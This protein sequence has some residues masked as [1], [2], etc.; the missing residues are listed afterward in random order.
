MVDGAE[1]VGVT[2]TAV[3]VPVNGFDGVPRAHVTTLWLGDVDFEGT[4]ETVAQVLSTVDDPVWAGVAEVVGVDDTFG[5]EDEQ[6]TVLLV[7][8]EWFVRLREALLAGGLL[9]ASEFTEFK[10]HVTLG[11]T[12]LSDDELGAALDLV[13]STVSFEGVQVGS[14]EADRFVE[15]DDM[16]DVVDVLGGDTNGEPYV[17]PEPGGDENDID[18][19]TGD[20]DELTVLVAS[21]ETNGTFEAVLIV[22]GVRTGDGREIA[23]GGLTHRDLPLPLMAQTVT[24]DHGGHAGAVLV[25]S[26]VELERSE[27]GEWVGRGVFDGGDVAQDVRRMVAEGVLNGVSADL[28]DVVVSWEFDG[29]IDSEG[30]PV[31]IMRIEQGRIMGATLTPFPAMQEAKVTLVASAAGD[32]IDGSASAVWSQ[33]IVDGDELTALV[34]SGR[35]VETTI[36]VSPPMEWFGVP[37]LDEPTPLRVLANG[38]VFGHVAT[39]GDCHIGFSGVCQ[40]VPRSKQNYGLFRTGQ[41]LC[42]EGTLVNTG[43]VYLDGGH[44]PLG[45]G[46]DGAKDWMA[47]T[48]AAVAD[49]AVYEDKFGVVVA[50]ALR[51]T[52]T[53]EQVRALRGSDLSPDWRSF[54]GNLEMVGLVAVNTSGFVVP[55]LTASGAVNDQGDVVSLVAAGVVRRGQVELERQVDVLSGT[56]TMLAARL[57]G[58]SGAV[59][60]LRVRSVANKFG[61]ASKPVVQLSVDSVGSATVCGCEH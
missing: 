30:F 36:P 55:A 32:R 18:V 14:W 47:D 23:S 8:S 57:D 52:A 6:V 25:G 21:G 24:P 35:P 40:S 60:T 43:P 46:V 28:D 50:G 39:F 44:A 61:V 3:V 19:D 13:G 5:P 17:E 16:G 59:N 22:E 41:V 4:V 15:F 27:S 33:P 45:L 26:I 7:E 56:V 37:V 58:L 49:V 42:A 29:D 53:A 2:P 12:P 54:N 1:N 31:E 10:P 51:S 9:S 11:D 38:R 20:G 48:C 34:A